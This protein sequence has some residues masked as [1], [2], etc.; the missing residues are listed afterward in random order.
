MDP[1]AQMP[2]SIC[3]QMMTQFV[4]VARSRMRVEI[5]GVE[6]IS[7]QWDQELH[8]DLQLLDLLVLNHPMTKTTAAKNDKNAQRIVGVAALSQKHPLVWTFA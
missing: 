2:F 8:Q 1:G 5:T 4:M 6:A 7:T 3:L